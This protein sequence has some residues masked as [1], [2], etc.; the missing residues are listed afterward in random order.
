MSPVVDLCPQLNDTIITDSYQSIY[1]FTINIANSK[2]SFIISVLI[3][4][5]LRSLVLVIIEF[6][7]YTV[8]VQL[9]IEPFY[10]DGNYLS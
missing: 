7:F 10:V 1:I 6:F 8:S 5:F 3:D 2:N 9:S 4:I